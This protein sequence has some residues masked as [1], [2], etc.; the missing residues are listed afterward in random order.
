MS[1]KCRILFGGGG[2]AG[3]LFPGVAIADELKERFGCHVRF[4]GTRN[5]IE[6]TSL[7]PMG[8][9]LSVVWISGIAR[10]RFLRNLLF[11]LKMAVSFVQ[12]VGIIR[13]YK[14]HAIVGT[15]GYASWPVVMAGSVMG[16]P[17][18]LQ[19]Q[20]IKPGLVTKIMAPKADTVYMSYPD[21]EQF[22]QGKARKILCGNPTRSSLDTMDR[23]DACKVFGLDPRRKTVFIFGGSQGSLF[24]NRLIAE[25]ADRLVTDLPVQLLWATGPRWADWVSTVAAGKNIKIYPFI[26]NM[27]AA[28]G[29]ADLT[30]CRS[31]A[32]TIAEITRLG[33]P[34]L[35]IPFAA[36]A[37]NHQQKNADIL[38]RKGAAAVLTEHDADA[39]TLLGKV[40]SLIQDHDALRGIADKARELG[41]PDAAPRIAEDIL[42]VIEESLY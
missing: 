30:V 16:V 36:A 24:I 8:Y 29:A 28:Y 15:G 40:T 14:P 23:A 34:A 39:E 5:G 9:A 38:S 17:L 1:G 22:L 21:T 42:S 26:D 20:N 12:A 3:H 41:R 27:A 4:V 13:R 18:F 6:Y 35:F 37:D 7:P 19:E 10:G 32:T 2:T 25:A 33:V 31:G 11:P